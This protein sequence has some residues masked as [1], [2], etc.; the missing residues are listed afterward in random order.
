MNVKSKLHVAFNLM[1]ASVVAVGSMPQ[2]AFATESMSQ[3]QTVMDDIEA[4][5]EGDA[6]SIDN[7][8]IVVSNETTEAQ[9]NDDTD[10][11]AETDAVAVAGLDMSGAVYVSG[12]KVREQTDGVVKKLAADVAAEKAKQEAEKKAAEE[13]EKKAKED[14]GKTADDKAAKPVEKAPAKPAPKP[15]ELKPAAPRSNM[16]G[17]YSH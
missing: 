2:A 7:D 5:I 8:D 17:Q 3:A 12:L 1:M 6:V 4:T 10:V 11:Q 15:V 14:A 16:F 13:A 9:S